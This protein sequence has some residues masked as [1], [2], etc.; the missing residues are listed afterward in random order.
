MRK[1]IKHF[2]ALLA[3]LT[4]A[5][6]S[7]ACEEVTNS[8]S[9]SSTTP[10]ATSIAD[11]AEVWG[12]HSSVKVLQ[13]KD[14][15]EDEKKAA[16]ID[17][18]VAKG[19]YESSQIIVSA[20]QDIDTY[21]FVVSDLTNQAGDT[22]ST[23]QVEVFH[24]KYMD[25]KTNYNGGITGMYPD[26][27]VPLENVKAVG[28][29]KVATDDN[30]GIFVRFNI[31]IN[32][33][34]GTYSGTFTLK[35]EKFSME[36]PVTIN[37]MDVVVSEENHV[38]SVYE[39][40]YGYYLGEQDGSQDMLDKYTE[41]LYE[42]R[43]CNSAIIPIHAS[44]F[45]DDDVQ[46]FV[47]TAYKYMQNPKCSFVCI[48]F[49]V[50]G[51]NQDLDIATSQ[52]FLRAMAQKSL[53]TGY[54]M[55]VKAGAYISS[56]DEPEGHHSDAKVQKL[57]KDWT[58]TCAGIANEIATDES[59]TSPIKD[60]LVESIKNCYN[61]VTAHNVERYAP[62]GVTTFCSSYSIYD[63][64][65]GRESLDYG[66]RWWYTCMYPRAPYANYQI[67]SG[68]T[69]TPIRL[70]GW[71]QANYDVVGDLFWATDSYYEHIQ[72]ASGS[73]IKYIEDYYSHAHR[74]PNTNGDGY[75]LYPGAA[76]GVDGPVASL[77]LDAIRDSYEDYE[78]LLALKE[79]YNEFGATLGENAFNADALFESLASSLYNGILPTADTNDFISA[80][81]ALFELVLLNQSSANL[82]LM[83]YEDNTMGTKT[84]TFFTAKGTTITSN[85]KE[86]TN[87]QEI[88]EG[89]L[90]TISVDMTQ[91]INELTLAVTNN[92]ETYN[93]HTILGGESVT[94]T[95]GNMKLEDIT[96]EL[97]VKT[98]LLAND[99]ILPSMQSIKIELPNVAAGVEQTIRIGG[100][101]ISMINSDAQEANLK[102]N[103]NSEGSDPEIIISAKFSKSLVLVDLVAGE[104]LETGV[105]NI[106][107]SLSSLNWDKL[108]Q[109]EYIQ[110]RFG[111]V[112][113]EEARTVYLTS[114]TVY[115][116][117]VR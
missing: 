17:L 40:F 88:D 56:I 42:Y 116:K 7:V 101:F 95:A 64:E 117:E 105:N 89:I 84:F 102:L 107:M 111:G 91:P 78:I 59:I 70:R 75:L 37:V 12:C 13:D 2:V 65:E 83:D 66:E 10:E 45:S 73:T 39:N 67:D 1:N 3:A 38:K 4:M 19:E 54:N 100:D 93:Y 50:G 25:I 98:T 35:L 16:A 82:Y 68:L 76:Y 71:Q 51:S 74:F 8:E 103:W 20:L 29:N 55:F 94:K 81:K 48:P 33:P 53:E 22:I 104:K 15:Y 41:F 96:S 79:K 112:D 60:E 115:K 114:M 106:K 72:N 23:E 97:N 36:I 30:Q 113:G 21:D 24:E 85:G 34:V 9:S 28:E 63:T 46:L 80:R 61:I 69:S 49:R 52:R 14:I 32:Q 43:I 62:L 86:V 44:A 6:P 47:E 58:N 92:G 26:A 18:L 5:L 77:R 109:L 90:W 99:P 31:P 87:K 27:I 11:L 108:G 57:C 110:I